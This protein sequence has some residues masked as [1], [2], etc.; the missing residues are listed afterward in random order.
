MR[1]PSVPDL[2]SVASRRPL[3]PQFSC[4][5]IFSRHTLLD[6]MPDPVAAAE[7][8]ALQEAQRLLRDNIVSPLVRPFSRSCL[9]E[10][11]RTAFN[12]AADN[13]LRADGCCNALDRPPRHRPLPFLAL[14]QQI[15]YRPPPFPRLRRP[16]HLCGS[17]RHRIDK[18]VDVLKYH[19][20]FREP[21]CAGVLAALVLEL[22][23][24]YRS[25]RGVLSDLLRV[26]VFFVFLR[27]ASPD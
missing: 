7:A 18:L 6:N 3:R 19:L 5:C 14:L 23:F 15:P 11:R 27:L 13:P 17:R 4:A 16:T 12:R 24:L 8:A 9:F 22:R 10:N 1:R 20:E 21:G 25:D 26:R 2:L